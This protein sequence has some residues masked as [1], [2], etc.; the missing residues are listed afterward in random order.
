VK[1]AGDLKKERDVL[2]VVRKESRSTFS[3]KGE[4]ELGAK[5]GK[6]EA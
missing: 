4:G 5:Q 6:E 2:G 1:D 3:P